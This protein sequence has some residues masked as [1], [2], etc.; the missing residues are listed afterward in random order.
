M[1][2]FPID[3]IVAILKRESEDWNVPVVTLIALQQKD[4]FKVLLSTII[5]LRTKD[6]ITIKASRR[7]F[8]L[9]SRPEDIL[10]VTT[11]QIEEAIYPAG[12]YRQKAIRIK[13]ICFR[14]IEEFSSQVP[15]EI[16]TLLT[17]PGIG[18]K[19]A[20]LILAEGYSIPA[21]CVDTHVHR[22]SNRLG[23]IKTRTPQETE[24]V[25]RGTLP[26]KYWIQYNTLL[27]AFGQKICR[28]VSPWCS[29][30]PVNRYCQKVG[31][32]TSR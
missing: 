25:L 5:S 16:E 20:N 9:L 14:L 8:E 1:N 28:P 18:R 17:F 30:C 2:L 4:P 3:T 31:V 23:Y 12:F 29:I 22:I 13:K 32:T 10:N 24:E 7:L 6:E 11:S 27:V 15:Q 19:T 26:K 21:I